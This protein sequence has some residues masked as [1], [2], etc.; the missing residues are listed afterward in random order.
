MPPPVLVVDGE[1]EQAARLSL[2]DLRALPAAAQIPDISRFHPQ[3]RGTGVHLE[4]VLA[5]VQPRA[6]ATYLTLHAPADNFAA[7]I[8]LAGIA[9][10]GILVYALEGEPL[11]A[12]QGGPFRFLIRNPAA[13]HTAELDDCANVKF[14]ERLELTAGK[15]RDT[16]PA[17]EAE[18]A[19]LHAAE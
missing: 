18:H 10:E 19:H 8:P 1:V 17:T 7:S 2:D 6:A 14:V 16:R 13:C 3:R 4:A 9:G 15:G 12:R 5:L 11:P